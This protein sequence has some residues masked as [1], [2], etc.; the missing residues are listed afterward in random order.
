MRIRLIIHCLP[1]RRRRPTR[2]AVGL[3]GVAAL[4][5]SGCRGDSGGHIDYAPPSPSAT[6]LVIS[7][8][9]RSPL[10]FAIK[11]RPGDGLE[12]G[13]S[14]STTSDGRTCI[15]AKAIF[16]TAGKDNL[17]GF[18]A[19]P[20]DCRIQQEPRNGQ[21]GHYRTVD[22]VRAVNGN[23]IRSV[24]IDTALGPAEVFSQ[25]YEECTNSCR[26][27]NEPAA[28]ISLTAPSDIKYPSL[29]VYGPH[30]IIDTAQL[31]G[32]LKLVDP[33]R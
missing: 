14:L 4:L 22:D 19:V 5:F 32:Y 1:P 27:Y 2:C 6:D 7:R 20:E 30:G 10:A 17:L 31:I 28:I 25:K 29:E 16:R 15:V 3:L 23:G 8:L 9:D 12:P 11:A 24:R 21:H 26:T 33:L 13:G 18:E